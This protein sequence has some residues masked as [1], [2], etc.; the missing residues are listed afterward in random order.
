LLVIGC[1]CEASGCGAVRLTVAAAGAGG[2][3]AAGNAA[4]AGAPDGGAP[5]S[6]AAGGGTGAAGAAAPSAAAAPLLGAADGGASAAT[7]IPLVTPIIA[8][9]TSATGNRGGD[10]R[11]NALFR[12]NFEI[13][14]SARDG[15]GANTLPLLQSRAETLKSV[16]DGI[17]RNFS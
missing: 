13:D 11:N 17:F 2:C 8:A 10:N 3:G 4:G 12:A 1:F 7:A 16:T 9:R 15:T 14:D 6:G 5:S